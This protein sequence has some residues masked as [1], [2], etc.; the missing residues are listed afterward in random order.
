MSQII[1]YFLPFVI[2][3]I[4]ACNT[5]NIENSC[6]N[7]PIGVT[8]KDIEMMSEYGIDNHYLEMM[9]WLKKCDKKEFKR[10][11]KIKS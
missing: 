11:M 8:K 10:L 3:A 4:P 2:L 1:R 6:S 7:K 9:I 5:M